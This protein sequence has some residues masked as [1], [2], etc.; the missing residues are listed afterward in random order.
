MRAKAER[1][2]AAPG[3]A[4]VQ[5]ALEHRKLVERAKGVLMEA[6]HLALPDFLLPTAHAIDLPRVRLLALGYAERGP[7]SFA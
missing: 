7:P 4:A 6:L 2:R 5:E 1:S 3:S